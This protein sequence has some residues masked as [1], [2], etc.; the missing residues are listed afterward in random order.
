ME[1]TSAPLAAAN[2]KAVRQNGG[3][4]AVNVFPEVKNGQPVATVT[5]LRNGQF[6]TVAEP[7]S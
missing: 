2:E 1:K 4:R 6:K 7:L 3:A 5:L